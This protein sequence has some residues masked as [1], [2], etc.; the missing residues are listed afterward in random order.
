MPSSPPNTPTQEIAVHK[1]GYTEVPRANQVA[2]SSAHAAAVRENSGGLFDKILLATQT[3]HTLVEVGS[4]PGASITTPKIQ[5][6][7]EGER[8][9]VLSLVHSPPCGVDSL[10]QPMAL[11][12]SLVHSPPCGVDSLLQPMALAILSTTFGVVVHGI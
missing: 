10:L 12:M 4:L 5:R 9:R 11:A 3:C 8:N 2:E 1:F 6:E 7:R